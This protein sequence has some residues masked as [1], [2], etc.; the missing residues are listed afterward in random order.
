[1]LCPAGMQPY[2][3]AIIIF[4]SF[5]FTF[6]SFT[7]HIYRTINLLLLH[8]QFPHSQWFTDKF[9]SLTVSVIG[10]SI[11]LIPSCSLGV[12]IIV[13][14]YMNFTLIQQY[15]R[16]PSILSVQILPHIINFSFLSSNRRLFCTEYN[17]FNCTRK[18]I[19]SICTIKR[20]KRKIIY[21]VEIIPIFKYLYFIFAFKLYYKFLKF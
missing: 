14:I 18:L 3:Y 1:M 4:P 5:F 13:I 20:T 2:F 10:R 21:F 9:I 6:L 19:Y 11:S 16:Q 17:R 7:F 15:Q 12:A 8:R